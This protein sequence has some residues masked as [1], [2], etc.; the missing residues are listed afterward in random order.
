MHGWD[1]KAQHKNKTLNQKQRLRDIWS[2][3]STGISLLMQQGGN[4][5]CSKML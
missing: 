4:G 3:Y 5:L 2:L 1:Q